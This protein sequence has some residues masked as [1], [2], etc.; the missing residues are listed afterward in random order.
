MDSKRRVL[1]AEDHPGTI[2]VMQTELEVLGYEVV[3]AQ[4]GQEAVEKAATESP[5]LIVMDIIMPK[6]DG[7]QATARIREN[8]RTRD[9]PIL[10]A[11]A[12]ARPGDREK[13]LESGCDGY[14]AKPF[15]HRQLGAA[16]DRLFEARE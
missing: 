12:L 3:V 14:I 11:T 1:L 9:I 4:D 13:C 15:T 6:L 10:A 16:I 5:D 2:E 7:F 8:P